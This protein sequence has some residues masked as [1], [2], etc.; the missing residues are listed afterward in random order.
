MG[1]TNAGPTPIQALVCM[2]ALAITVHNMPLHKHQQR[3]MR[4]QDNL[5]YCQT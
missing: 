1:L 4:L 3:Y 2:L 5:A